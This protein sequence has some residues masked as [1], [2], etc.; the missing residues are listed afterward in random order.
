MT[1]EMILNSEILKEAELDKIAGGNRQ[2]L[3]LDTQLFKAMGYMEQSYTLSQ[4]NDSNVNEISSK[5]GMLWKKFNM[6]Y[7]YNDFGSDDHGSLNRNQ[8]IDKVI[9]DAGM[10]GYLDPKRF[11]TDTQQ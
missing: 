5:V 6:D 11:Y 9:W 10:G 4:I 3:A 1:N 2:Q 7:K 8:A